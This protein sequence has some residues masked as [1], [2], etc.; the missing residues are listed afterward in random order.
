LSFYF[1]EF[2]FFI[3]IAEE[4]RTMPDIDKK[5]EQ[6]DD[7]G[8]EFDFDDDDEEE[9][10]PDIGSNLKQD[11]IYNEYSVCISR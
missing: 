10:V 3:D 6:M 11:H 4:M 9:E 1:F 2:L 7:N 8:D 5:L